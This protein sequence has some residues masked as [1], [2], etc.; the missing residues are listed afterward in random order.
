MD[1]TSGP[2]QFERLQSMF[3][4]AVKEELKGLNTSFLFIGAWKT[5]FNWHI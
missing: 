4:H 5:F 2:W 3:S 1:S